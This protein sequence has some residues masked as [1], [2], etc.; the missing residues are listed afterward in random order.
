MILVALGAN[1]PSC[2]GAPRETL[3]RAVAELAARGLTVAARSRLFLTEPV[4]RSAQPWYANQVIA[5]E[6]DRSP[7]ALLAVL[8]EVEALFGRERSERNAA[9]TLDLDLVAYHD[10]RLDT[11]ELVLPH[12]RLHERAFVLAPLADIAPGW[13]HPVLGESVE[14]LLARTDRTNVRAMA[15]VPLL[16]GVVNVTPDSFSDGGRFETTDKAI[17]HAVALIE[18]GAD[19]LDIG[20]ESTRPESQPLAPEDEQARILPVIAAVAAEAARRRRLISVDTR[21]AATMR[22]ALA[23]GASMINDITALESA[24][25]RRIVAEAG[26]PAILMHM[27]GT[28][29]TMQINPTY[30]DVVGEVA[31]T[32]ARARDRAVA[33]GIRPDRIWLDPGLGFGKTLEHNLALL[34]ATPRFKALGQPV[35]VGASRKSFIGKVDRAGPA[36]DRLGGSI[37]AALAAATRGADAVRVHDVAETRQALATWSAIEGKAAG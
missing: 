22:A 14:A 2:E 15:P 20:G 18:Q 36:D 10:L 6:T 26:V 37:A 7:Q 29:Q 27:Q 5:V 4:P 31:D 1:L 23:A 25:A 33:D 17:A 8:F 12:P 11:P 3:R 35:L 24:E 19:I 34:D 32:L 16:M 28:P 9:R 21:H 13:R 30:A